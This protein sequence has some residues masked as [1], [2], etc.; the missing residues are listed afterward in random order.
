VPGSG[1]VASANFLGYLLGALV[2]AWPRLPGRR[3]AWFLGAVAASGLTTAAMALGDTLAAFMALRFVGGMASAFVL[4]FA[5]TLVLERLARA[6]RGG[7][8]SVHFAGVGA[9]V[10]VSAVLVSV[11]AAYGADWRALWLA[12]GAVSLAALGALFGLVPE[13]PEPA[14]PAPAAAPSVDGDRRLHRLIAAYGLFGFGYV[15]TA[16][17]VSAMVRTLPALQPAEP[18]VWLVF[19]LAAVPSVAL[20]VGLGRTLGVARGFAL[21]C[22]VEAAG[23]AMTVLVVDAAAVVLGAALLGGTF[24][25]LTAL[26]LMLARSLSRGDP[27]RNIGLM[28]AAFGLGQMIGPAWAGYAFDITGSLLLPSLTASAAL[29]VAAALVTDRRRLPSVV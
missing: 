1:L 22:L 10:A 18:V 3:R 7:L 20:W 23:V 11:L 2:A 19:G 21:A 28:T 8:A 14:A 5:S 25:G 29:L 9:G 13:G 15:I 16:T 17:F 6:G 4:V 26:G 12:G 27:R 24:M